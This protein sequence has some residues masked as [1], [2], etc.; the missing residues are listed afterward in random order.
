MPFLKAEYRISGERILAGWSRFGVFATFGMIHKP[1]LFS[2]Y[3]VRSSAPNGEAL[4]PALNRL[5]SNNPTLSA[6]LHISIGTEGNEHRRKD[7]FDALESLLAEHAPPTL[8]WRTEVI[9][10]AGHSETFEPG[11]RSGLLFYFAD[12]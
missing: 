12:R 8:R 2:G 5:L 6:V 9:E 11:L 1:G 4:H 3:I 7:A 10:G